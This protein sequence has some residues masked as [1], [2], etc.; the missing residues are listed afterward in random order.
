MTPVAA[1][2]R[3]PYVGPALRRAEWLL[4]DSPLRAFGG[5]WIGAFRK[6]N[7]G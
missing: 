3:L 4:C 5:F 2:L 1:A 7:T 6:E